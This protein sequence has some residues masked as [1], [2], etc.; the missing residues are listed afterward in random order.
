VRHDELRRSLAPVIG[1]NLSRLRYQCGLTQ[2][3]VSERAEINT[4]H[5]QKIEAGQVCPSFPLLVK[6]KRVLEANWEDLL[7]EIN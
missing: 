6:L 5:Y 7:H 4:R 3:L 2:E 1:K